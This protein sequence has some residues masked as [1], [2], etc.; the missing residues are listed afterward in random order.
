MN[1]VKV[2]FTIP[3]EVRDRLWRQVDAGRRSSFVAAAIREKLT[4]LEQENVRSALRE[5][6]AATREE[7]AEINA[8]WESATLETWP[9]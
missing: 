5:G 9:G 3:R 8:A 2:D 6:Y 4:R 1:A 7:D